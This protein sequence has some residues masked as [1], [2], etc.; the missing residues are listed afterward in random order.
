MVAEVV[1]NEFPS[2]VDA[3]SVAFVV[4]PVIILVLLSVVKFSLSTVTVDEGAMFV[5]VV[6]GGL[7]SP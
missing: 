6:A 7:T 3:V 4:D 2:I 5:T 1:G